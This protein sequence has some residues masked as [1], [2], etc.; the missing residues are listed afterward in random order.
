MIL[1]SG[2]RLQYEEGCSRLSLLTLTSKCWVS[3]DPI[4]PVHFQYNVSLFQATM[5]WKEWCGYEGRWRVWGRHLVARFATWLK[6]YT[7]PTKISLALPASF[8]SLISPQ[9]AHAHAHSHS[10]TLTHTQV[11]LSKSLRGWLRQIYEDVH[12]CNV[13]AVTGISSF[14]WHAFQR[15]LCCW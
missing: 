10:H 12:I 4:Y 5:T 3:L 8:P 2:K 9:H 1:V 7:E 6:P 11:L 15:F 13:I 14:S